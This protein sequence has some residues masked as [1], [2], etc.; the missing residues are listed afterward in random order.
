MENNPIST[1]IDEKQKTGNIIAKVKKNKKARESKTASDI[2]NENN[3]PSKKVA[4]FLF[5][6]IKPPFDLLPKRL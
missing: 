4:E 5:H 1:R 3:K 6:E 2:A